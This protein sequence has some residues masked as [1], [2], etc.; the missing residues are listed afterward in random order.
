MHRAAALVAI[1]ALSLAV[2]AAAEPLPV[3]VTSW[4]AFKAHFGRAYAPAEEAYRR[5][6]FAASVHRVTAHNARGASWRAGLNQFSDMTADEFLAAVLPPQ[7][8][9]DCSATGNR[10]APRPRST[11]LPQAVDWRKAGFVTSVRN[12]GHCGSVRVLA[13]W[14]ACCPNLTLS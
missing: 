12:Q 7:A 11:P 3:S 2:A 10:W 5:G 1:L 4:A 8:P 6:V 9:Q 13:R 14:P